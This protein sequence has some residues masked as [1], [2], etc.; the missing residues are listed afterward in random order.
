MNY[1]ATPEPTHCNIELEQELLGAILTPVGAA[2]LNAI[3]RIIT[4]ED[5]FDLNH[6]KLFASFLEAHGQGRARSI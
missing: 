2:V 6:Q 3:D 5:F 1:H 4:P